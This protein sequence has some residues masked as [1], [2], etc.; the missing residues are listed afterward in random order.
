VRV[1]VSPCALQGGL[2]QLAEA[3]ASN[4]AQS[5]FESQGRYFTPSW[6]SG[7]GIWL[8]T[9]RS[10]VRIPPRGLIEAQSRWSARLPVTEKITGSSPVVS[11]STARSAVDG[12]PA[13]EAGGRGFE[14]H[15]AVWD[16]EVAVTSLVVI[17]GSRVRIPLVPFE[18]QRSW[19]PRGLQPRRPGF[20]S[21][22]TCSLLCSQA[23]RQP[24]HTR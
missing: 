11:T 5:G 24:A 14:S 8:R 10:W 15:R 20:D 23:A 22:L 3:A 13:P 19:R 12:T 6:P 2:A 18:G 16:H 4:T 7:Q 1:R 21:L 17:Q 9:R